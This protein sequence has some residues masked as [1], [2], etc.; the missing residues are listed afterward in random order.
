[1]LLTGIPVQVSEAEFAR[2]NAAA[3][4]KRMSVDAWVRTTINEYLRAAAGADGPRRAAN[5]EQEPA[6]RRSRPL[7]WD[8]EVDDLRECE[9]CGWWLD[10]DATRRKR[11]CS[12][13]CRIRA[14]RFRRR[15]RTVAM[16]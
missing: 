5:S 14:W 2:W 4:R 12:D 6:H 3:Q 7:A 15:A 8:D 16:K 11:Y 13:T 9:Y 1:M 10:L